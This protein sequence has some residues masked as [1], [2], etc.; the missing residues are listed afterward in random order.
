MGRLT[1]N[2][3]LSFAQFEREVWF[4]LHRLLDR[5]RSSARDELLKKG[6]ELLRI[7]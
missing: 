1:L 6:G 7:L 2:M 5:A 4:Q 3:L